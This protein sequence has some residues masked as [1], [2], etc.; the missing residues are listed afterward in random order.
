MSQQQSV[1]TAILATITLPVTV[2]PS[3]DRDILTCKARLGGLTL[4]QFQATPKWNLTLV[5]SL[6]KNSKE[7]IRQRGIPPLGMTLV[8]QFS[9]SVVSNSATPWIA[10]RQ[11]SL[12][13]TNSRSL[14]KFMA[15]E[16]VTPSNHL[17]LCHPLLL[18]PSIFSS[19]RVF[20]NESVFPSGGQ[21]IR[22]SDSASILPK[23]I[24]D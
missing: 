14:L 8:S 18:P 7:I 16:S 21:N 5:N 22:V 23:N 6:H 9:R 4:K 10:A 1:T 20:S 15:I 11:A 13:I 3:C 12:S 2:S 19:I 24:Q 17:I